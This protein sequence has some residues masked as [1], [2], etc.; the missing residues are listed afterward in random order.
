M[1]TIV[2]VSEPGPGGFQC[3]DQLRE[4]S[5]KLIR[6]DL[7]YYLQVA[8]HGYW[9]PKMPVDYL[10]NGSRTGYPE[11]VAF[12]PLWPK[13]VGWV[14]IPFGQTY[15]HVFYVGIV[16]ANLLAL[17]TFWLLYRLVAERFDDQTAR[18][19]VF[20]LA[21]NPFTVTFAAGYGEALFIPLTLAVFLLVRKERWLLAGLAGALTTLT[22]PN[23]VLIMILFAVVLVQRYGWRD[24]FTRNEIGTKLKIVGSA[25]MVPLGLLS[26]IAYLWLKWD[27]PFAFSRWQTNFWGRTTQWPWQP[28]YKAFENAILTPSATETASKFNSTDSLWELLFLFLPLTALALTWRQLPLEYLLFGIAIFLMTI[29]VPTGAEEPLASIGRHLGGTFSI[30][31]AYALL[32]RKVRAQQLLLVVTL[33]FFGLFTAYYAVGRWMA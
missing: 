32:S 25:A 29:T 8:T 2:S 27:D 15:W 11:A 18:W 20:F 21:F 31:V 1:L 26:Y 4:C 23:G 24:L 5:K 3:F 7:G 28:I 16:L 10:P 9:D 17:V 19:S 14:S 33:A 13:L 30:A 12:F 6:F 22:K